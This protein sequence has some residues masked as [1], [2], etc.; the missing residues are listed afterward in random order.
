MALA[1][2]QTQ[3]RPAFGLAK[4]ERETLHERAYEEVK[5]AIMGGAIAPGE[6]MTIRALAKALGTSVM[7]VR[8]ALRRLVAERALELLPNRSVSLPVMTAEKF[9]EIVRIRLALE[10]LMAETAAKHITPDELKRMSR[11]NEEMIAKLRQG[12]KKYLALNQEF[13][14]QLYLAA[15]MPQAM[16]IVE[17][18]WL[19]IGPFLHHVTTDFGQSD[20]LGH[21]EAMLK[22]LG[23]RDGN[24][25]RAA[26]EADISEAAQTILESLR[27]A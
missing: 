6:P 1:A 19:Q 10:G 3:Q 25:A 11:L 7:P 12:S 18:L 4:L 21:H 24:K 15:R 13:H 9:D 27:Q 22:A 5:K 20:F 17:T 2:A 8:E 26:I 16:S 23:K 14:F